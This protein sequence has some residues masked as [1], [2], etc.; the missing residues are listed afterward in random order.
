[1]DREQ[2]DEEEEERG[3]RQPF[4]TGRSAGWEEDA[5]RAAGGA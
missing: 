5:L 4:S 2:V 3:K 1:M